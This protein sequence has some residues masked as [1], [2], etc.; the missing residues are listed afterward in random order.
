MDLREQIGLYLAGLH[1]ASASEHT[2]RN[3][4]VDLDQFHAY[5]TP[6][7]GSTPAVEQIDGTALREWLGGL[8]HLNLSV[9]T[10]RRKIACIR[11]FFKYLMREKLLTVNPT[12]QLKTPKAPQ[13]LP[14]VTRWTR[15]AVDRCTPR[16]SARRRP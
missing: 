7:P 6:L 9:V 1:R 11:S 16:T 5:F 13:P 4:G 8:Y 3:Y 14:K 15:P 12:R 10:I 2:I